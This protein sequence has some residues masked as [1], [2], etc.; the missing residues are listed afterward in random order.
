MRRQKKNQS[1]PVIFFVCGLLIMSGCTRKEELLILDGQDG[2]K[3]AVQE[4]QAG[5]S[6]SAD[7]QEVLTEE[8]ASADERTEAAEA[9]YEEVIEPQ[10]IFVHVCGA[11]MMPGVY[12]LESGSRVYE[13]VKAAGGF[14]D[15]A[16]ES[17]VNQAQILP[18]GVKLTIPTVEETLAMAADEEEERLADW[19]ETP[20]GQ[21]ESYAEETGETGKININTASE[22]ELCRIPGIG[23]TRA[24]AIIAYRQEHG[25]FARIEDIMKVAGIKEGTFEK[26]KDSIKV[27]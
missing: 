17:Y 10:M 5:V 16:D 6:D 3:S 15:D 26:I 25:D 1:I 21:P 22:A 11:V 18:D 2:D 24:T 4:S 20:G 23:E 9:V 12:E 13:A 19:M 27:D 8:S 14:T 7:G